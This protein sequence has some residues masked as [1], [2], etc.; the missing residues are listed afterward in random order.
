MAKKAGDESDLS[1][2]SAGHIL[3]LCSVIGVSGKIEPMEQEDPL[4]MS[5]RGWPV[6]IEIGILTLPILFLKRER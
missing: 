6:K 3:G 2:S 1:T 4:R 5:R